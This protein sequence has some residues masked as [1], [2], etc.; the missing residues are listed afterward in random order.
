MGIYLFSPDIHEVIS[1]L[2]PSARGELEITD[3]IQGLVAAG[4]RVLGTIV[5]AWWL[6]T[7]TVDDLLEANRVIL[8]ERDSPRID[9]VVDSTSSVHGNVAIGVGTRVESSAITGPAAIARNSVLRGCSIGPH[10]SI[11]ENCVVENTDI[12]NSIVMDDSRVSSVRLE[13][14]VTG[15]RARVVGSA[16]VPN[17]SLRLLLGDECAVEVDA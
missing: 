16:S 7:G 17:R 4:G 15:R 10:V 13:A 2:R 3:A 5:H 8:E 14:S 6:D 12:R 9:G 11:G 1:E